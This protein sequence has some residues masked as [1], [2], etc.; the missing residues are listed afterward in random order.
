MTM[1][2]I[3]YIL[4]LISSIAFAQRGERLRAYKTAFITEALEL[5]SGEAE[6]FWPVYNTYNDKLRELRHLER[7]EV[8]ELAEGDFEGLSEEEANSMLDKISTIKS[9]EFQ[10]HKEMLESLR[11][12]LP[13]KKVIK[14]KRAEEAFKMQLLEKVKSKRGHRP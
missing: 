4:F 2:R 1:K 3:V 8:F 14:L 11:N 9:K 5:T 12:I 7:K 6:K 13:A 10:Y